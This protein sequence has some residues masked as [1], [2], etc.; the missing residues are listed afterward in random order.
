MK[1]FIAV[2]IILALASFLIL[3]H[4]ILGKSASGKRLERIKKSKNY[5]NG[6]FKN[7]SETPQL[8]EGATMG[9]LIWKML[10]GKKAPNLSPKALIPSIKTDLTSIHNNSLVWFGH[11][12]YI[13][14][15]ENIV[16]LVDPVLSGSA[17]PIPG[18]V[19]AYNGAD[20]YKAKDIPKIDYLIISH[21]HF[22]HLDY[23]T[24]K[25]IIPR[26]SH[27]ICGL[28]VGA[29]LEHWGFRPNQITELDWYENT[30]VPG[31]IT[32]TSTPARHFSGRSLNSNQTLWSSYVLK[33]PYKSFFIGGDSGYDTHFK[34]IG[35]K[36]GPFD[37]AILENGQYNKS[38]KHIHTLPDELMQVQK[39]LNARVI[40]PVHNSKFTLADHAWSDPQELAY[41]HAKEANQKIITPK[42]GEIVNLSDSTQVFS[43]W[44]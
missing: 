33:T 32:I 22:D 5:R 21:D 18:P 29:H 2:I 15:L 7:L 24:I 20:I 17:S 12:S 1:I 9:G 38:W 43:R 30:I 44:W 8:T 40:F 3:Q 6:S 19:K 10:F 23:K 28:G 39:D 34:E 25:E 13:F 4:P 27:V 14:K 36:F 41:V 31:G 16:F 26:V 35:E 37:L 42:I 11:S